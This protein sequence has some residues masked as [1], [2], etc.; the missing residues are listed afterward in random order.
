LAALG[1]LVWEPV[2]ELV[3]DGLEEEAVRSL[4]HVLSSHLNQW[5][6]WEYILLLRVMVLLLADVVAEVV[7]GAAVEEG[8][9]LVV[10]VVDVVVLESAVV[11]APVAEVEAPVADAVAPP[12]SWN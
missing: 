7:D 9:V 10:M 4:V 8:V 11:E 1:A 12:R 5:D 2:P 3:V 6:H